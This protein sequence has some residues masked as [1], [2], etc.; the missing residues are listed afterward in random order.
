M[1]RGF[2][3][4][5]TLAASCAAAAP[6][7]AQPAGEAIGVRSAARSVL[8]ERA[9]AIVTVK[10][11][12]RQRF[13]AE[14]REQ[15]S[16]ESTLE[17]AGT[18]L[19]PEGLTVVSDAA[20]NPAAM[21]GSPPGAGV[22]L[23]SETGEVK[24]ALSDGREVPA[25]FV[26]RDSDLDLAFLVPE[27]PLEAHPHV[28]LV[29]AVEAGPLDDLIL[30]FPLSKALNREVGVLVTAVR[31]VIRKPRVFLAI[32]VF[33]GMQSLG[34]P[35]FDAAGRAVGLVVLRRS[36]VPVR[37]S[38]GFRDMFDL[39][40]PVVLSAGDVSGVASQALAVARGRE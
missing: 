1:R 4:V 6:S 39:L 12:L 30:L 36:P 21:A 16:A 32:D 26:L 3:T 8:S 33:D 2:W 23:D 34:C 38:G 11:L 13:I 19:T 5:V 35:A 24:L 10:L 27:E 7:P 28:E 31:G 40:N 22:R 25:R 15:H 37:P 17:L 9:P 14:G 20:S 18:V 29:E